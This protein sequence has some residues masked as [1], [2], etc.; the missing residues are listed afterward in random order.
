MAALF[1]VYAGHDDQVDGLAQ[2]HKI[3]LRQVIDLNM[4]PFRRYLTYRPSCSG[5]PWLELLLSRVDLG[6]VGD[7]LAESLLEVFAQNFFLNFVPLALVLLELR[8]KLKQV[9]GL[10]ELQ[11]V[12]DRNVVGDLVV[13]F[14]E[15]ELRDHAFESPEALFPHLKEPFN[16]VLNPLANFALLQDCSEQPKDFVAAGGCGTLEHLATL[17][18]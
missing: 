10:F 11:Q 17:F 13:V 4:F 15:V 6:L 3:L 12:I 7:L 1:E 8:V 9:A 2:L 18:H 14:H 16:N 5:G